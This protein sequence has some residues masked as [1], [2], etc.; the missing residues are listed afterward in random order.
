MLLNPGLLQLLFVPTGLGETQ[1]VVEATTAWANCVDPAKSA[2]VNATTSESFFICM[3]FPFSTANGAR[4]PLSPHLPSSGIIVGTGIADVPLRESGHGRG[5]RSDTQGEGATCPWRERRLLP[6][7]DTLGRPA[8]RRSPPAR[9]TP[10]E[11]QRSNHSPAPSVQTSRRIRP[12]SYCH[13]RRLICPKR[14][15][16][17]GTSRDTGFAW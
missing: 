11:T 10:R 14:I 13:S 9:A 3:C 7:P 6:G 5:R 12:T 17:P 4:F 16:A 2:V 15:T 1:F 8:S